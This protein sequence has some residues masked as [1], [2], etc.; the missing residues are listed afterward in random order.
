MQPPRISVSK[1]VTGE[2]ATPRS[3]PMAVLGSK[4]EEWA[5]PGAVAIEKFGPC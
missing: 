2:T 3:Y 1:V 4:F 5:D